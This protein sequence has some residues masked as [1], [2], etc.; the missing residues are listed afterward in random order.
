ML[1]LYHIG[2]QQQTQIRAPMRSPATVWPTWKRQR[3]ELNDAIDDLQDQLK[4]GEKMIASMNQTRKA[5]E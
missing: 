4:W 5:A 1:D 2:D 3:D